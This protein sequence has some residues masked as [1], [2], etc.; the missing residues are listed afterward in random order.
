MFTFLLIA[1]ILNFFFKTLFA[2]IIFTLFF[3]FIFFENIIIVF[4]EIIN[5]YDFLTLINI[6][7][8]IIKIYDIVLKKL[9]TIDLI[10][11]NFIFF[12][13]K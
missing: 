11:K 9:K 13:N 5:K 1:F 12:T 3:F 2:H 6:L 7:K 8:N 4:V 10:N